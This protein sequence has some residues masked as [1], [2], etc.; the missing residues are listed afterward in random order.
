MRSKWAVGGT[1]GIY[2][3]VPYKIDSVYLVILDY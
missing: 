3:V 2:D 1:G